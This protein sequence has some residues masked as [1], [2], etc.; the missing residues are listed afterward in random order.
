[1]FRVRGE[2]PALFDENDN[3]ALFFTEG[4]SQYLDELDNQNYG[5]FVEKWTNLTDAGEVASTL[6]KEV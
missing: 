2:L 5:Y 6:L 4:Q 1:M 3:R